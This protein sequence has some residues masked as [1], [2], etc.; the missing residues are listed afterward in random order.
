MEQR[1]LTNEE[2]NLTRKDRHENVVSTL[3]TDLQIF[4]ISTFCNNYYIYFMIS[5]GDTCYM[6]SRLIDAD[7][8]S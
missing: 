5:C 6:L 1:V 8:P 4:M 7:I 3:E 2:T